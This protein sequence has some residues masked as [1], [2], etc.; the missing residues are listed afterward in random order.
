M[1]LNFNS[2]L[3]KTRGKMAKEEKKVRRPQ[4]LKRAEQSEKRRLINK[5]F[6]SAVRTTVRDFED[7]L[8]TKDVESHKK[9]LNEVYSLMDKGV[10]KGIYKSNTASRTK[11][12]MAARLAKVS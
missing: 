2:E 4:A 6:K 10:K 7:A 3:S 9:A 11:A 8:K 5:G 12:R 1:L